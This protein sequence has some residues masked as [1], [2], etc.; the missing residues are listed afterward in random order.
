[1]TYKKAQFLGFII[2]VVIYVISWFIV[3]LMTE[4]T[5][6]IGCVSVLLSFLLSPSIKKVDSQS[7]DDFFVKWHLGKNNFKKIYA[8]FF[9]VAN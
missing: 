8:V 2:F 5:A 9:K 1:M 3:G 7:P 4:K 6:L